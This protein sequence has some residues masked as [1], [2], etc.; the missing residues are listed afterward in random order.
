MLKNNKRLLSVLLAVA[1][2]LVVSV[3][4]A[5]AAQTAGT[6]QYDN[7]TAYNYE[8]T[9]VAD[10]LA[11]ALQ[12]VPADVSYDP[13]VFVTE[14]DAEAVV[15]TIA[16]TSGG[17]NSSNLTFGAPTAEVIEDDEFYSQLAVTVTDAAVTG[18]ASFLAT[19]T[20][21]DSSTITVNITLVVNA[22]NVTLDD[23]SVT[24]SNPIYQIF[25]PK[26][27]TATPST[28]FTIL[29]SAT[30]PSVPASA[31]EDN[32]SYVTV[33]DGL[34]TG[35]NQELGLITASDV[36]GGYVSS[37][38]VNGTEYEAEDSEP[39]AGWQYRVYTLSSGTYTIDNYSAILGA[40]DYE[41]ED[42]QLV[43]WRYGA[44]GAVTFPSSF[45]DPGI[46]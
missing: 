2:M 19:Y 29:H 45:P 3:L 17:L 38:T 14:E 41:L 22:P 6:T 15:W 44:Y 25:E 46:F 8:F 37:I 27:T 11:A 36:S 12:V 21:P 13:T 26:G 42:G 4:P 28:D 43:Q 32:R 23:S 39:Y 1:M 7:L 30:L 35:Q 33:L 10:E 34:L 20:N 9:V 18:S 24:I 5:F 31:S 40:G 16:E